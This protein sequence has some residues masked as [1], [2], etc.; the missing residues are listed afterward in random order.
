M[1]SPPY[2]ALCCFVGY[3]TSHGSHSQ[4][5][6]TAHVSRIQGSG[7]AGA[8]SV[9]EQQLGADA[10]GYGTAYSGKCPSCSRHR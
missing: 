1:C 8:I 5:L 7:I 4:S 3:V 9:L 2:A 6:Y 10:L